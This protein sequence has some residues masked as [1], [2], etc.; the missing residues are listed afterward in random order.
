MFVKLLA[1]AA[2]ALVVWSAAARPSGAHGHKVSYRV[3]A[4]DTLW[5]I[6]ATHYGGDV[7]DAVW[8]IQRANRL[9]SS[10]I[11]PGETLVLP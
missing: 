9:S 6:A 3:R 1:L 4:S 2:A 11:R 10:S 8:R 5:T 7:R